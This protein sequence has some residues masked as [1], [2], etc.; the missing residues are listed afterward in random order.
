MRAS[1]LIFTFGANVH[2]PYTDGGY[3]NITSTINDLKYLGITQVRDGISDGLNGSAPIS[4]YITLAKAGIK[5]DFVVEGASTADVRAEFA[6]IDQVAAAVPGSVIAVEGPNEINNGQFSYNGAGGLQAA[7]MEQADIYQIAHQDSRLSGVSVYY[8][9]GYNAGSVPVGPAP[10]TTP[11]LADFDNQHPYPR[12]G[13]PP[14]PT[15]SRQVAVGNETS[16]T[17]P[18]VYTESGYSTNDVTSNVQAKYELDLLMDSASQGLSKTFLYELKDAYSPGSPQGNDGWGLFDYTGAAKPVATAIHNLTTLMQ[19]SGAQA[20]TFTP[21]SFTYSIMGLPSTGNSLLLQKSDGTNFIAVWNEPQIWNS[22]TASEVATPDQFVTVKLGK[23]YASVKVFDPLSGTQA[24]SQFSNVSSVT[25]DVT[26]HPLLVE[27]DPATAAAT[28]TSSTGTTSSTP[29]SSGSDTLVLD[30]SEIAAGGRDVQFAVSVDGVQIGGT[31]TVTA[32][33]AAAQSQDITLMGNFGPAGSH[34]VT[35]NFLNGYAT[36]ADAGRTLYVNAISLNGVTTFENSDLQYS[37]PYKYT[38][39]KSATPVVSNA[40]TQNT[41]VLNVAET[42]ASGQ[43]AQFLVSVDGQRVGGIQTV[44]ASAAAGASQ[45]VTLTGNFGTGPH[46]V[47]VDFVNGFSGRPTDAGRV[48]YVNAVSLDSQ[49]TFSNIALINGSAS[50]TVT[51]PSAPLASKAG[52][53]DTLVL[54]VAEAA[55]G[56]QDARFMVSVDG[57]LVGGIQ[58]VTASAAAGASQ[59]VALTGNFGTGSHNV[60]IDFL[61]GFTGN[62]NDFGRTLFVNSITL[63]GA[64]TTQNAVQTNAQA[65]SYVVTPPTSS[66]PST[67][68]TPPASTAPST[69]VTPPAS[70][71]GSDT[72]VLDVSEIAAGG[73]DVQFAVSVDGVQIGGTQTV[74]ASHAAA[75][76]Q[77]IT[78]MGNFGPAGSHTVTVNFLNGYATNAD[79]GRTLYVNAISL[80]GVT[81]FENSDLQYS[82]PYKYTIQKSATPVV[83]N[84]GTQNTLVLNVAETSASGQNAQFLVSVDGQRVGGIQTVTASAAAGASQNVT[85]TGNFGTGPHQVTVDFVNGFSGRPTDAGRVLY[86]NAVSLDS[87]A[88]FSNIALINGSASTTV[89]GPSAPLASQSGHARHI[90]PQGRRGSRRRPGCAVHGERRRAA[91]GR[92][93]DGHRLSRCR[94]QPERRPYR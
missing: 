94:C 92:H 29:T 19:D 69:T 12:L 93:S 10:S 78:L 22:A 17:A 1:D 34:T 67:T 39:Q 41:L 80:N 54:K 90:G 64:V 71:S 70:G 26:D 76:S 87:Q 18:L 23:T 45:N 2:T 52:T 44:T 42:S 11:G 66:T 21:S 50:T 13:Q 31:Q 49:A 5:F 75:Q 53:Q 77:D 46:Q 9:T 28:T 91:R 24:I 36:N 57:Q 32:S 48:L 73:R 89:T 84:A 4:S 86:V 20:T 15:N 85:L 16:P 74:T 59:N 83:S 51:G 6:L 61:N 68:V 56:G 82:G 27:V 30:V 14:Q 72:L 88:T 65:V 40:G 8:F 37:G 7:L 38:I 55:A 35:V 79:A 60:A 43:N 33:H 63:N 47:T 62:P 58:T 3:V 25:I 81:T